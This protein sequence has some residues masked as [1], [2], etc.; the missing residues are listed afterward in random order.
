MKSICNQKTS[1]SETDLD[2]QKWHFFV[3]NR[4]IALRSSLLFVRENRKASAAVLQC[5]AASRLFFA[6]STSF[7][8]L[9]SWIIFHTPNDTYK[10]SICIYNIYTCALP[11]LLNH[12][13]KPTFCIIFVASHLSRCLCA[14]NH[15]LPIWDLCSPSRC[16]PAFAQPDRA[17]PIQSMAFWG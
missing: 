7:E 11:G 3:Q 16:S 14:R 10:A 15:Q 12:L 9:D 5:L 6:M 2:C 8:F 13:F 4:R 1:R 17:S